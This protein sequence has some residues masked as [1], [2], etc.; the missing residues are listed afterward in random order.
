LA[1]T[2]IIQTIAALASKFIGPITG[3][4]FLGI[5]TKRANVRGVLIG[6]AVGLATGWVVDLPWLQ[7]RVNWM[8]TAPLGFVVTFIVGYAASLLSPSAGDTTARDS[9]FDDRELAASK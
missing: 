7:E 4:F 3:M 6:V 9:R 5:L 8:W 1:Q 2:P